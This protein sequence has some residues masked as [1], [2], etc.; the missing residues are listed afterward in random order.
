MTRIVLTVLWLSLLFATRALDATITW[1]YDPGLVHEANPLVRILGGGWTAILVAN[2]SICLFIG[3]ATLAWYRSKPRTDLAVRSHSAWDYAALLLFGRTMPQWQ[4]ILLRLTT[5]LPPRER[6]RLAGLAHLY[7]F[8]LPPVVVVASLVASA[9]WVTTYGWH[10]DW[11]VRLHRMLGYGILLVP[12]GITLV[13][14]EAAFFHIEF[15]RAK[16]AS[17]DMVLKGKKR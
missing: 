14:A 1:Y 11:A 7:G 6:E 15:H 13:W 9:V 12:V 16:R 3:W 17:T 8:V 4:F 2:V 5:I 10:L